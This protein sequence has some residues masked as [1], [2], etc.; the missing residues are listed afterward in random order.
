MAQYGPERALATLVSHALAD[1]AKRLNEDKEKIL[2]LWETSVREAI[3]ES[4]G[5][6][7][8]AIRN[9]LPKLIEKMAH[10]LAQTSPKNTA[11]LQTE[12]SIAREHGQQRATF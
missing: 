8:E 2:R 1:V 9:S 4:R 5:K 12:L 3:P 11:A 10:T 7:K 6:A